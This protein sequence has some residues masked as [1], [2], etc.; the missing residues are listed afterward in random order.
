MRYWSQ[1]TS[2]EKMVLCN[3]VQIL[4]GIGHSRGDIAKITNVFPVV[5][6]HVLYKLRNDRGFEDLSFEAERRA[7]PVHPNCRIGSGRNVRPKHIHPDTWVGSEM[8]W[9]A[10]D[11]AF[12][13]AM[14][15]HPE[16]RPTDVSLKPFNRCRGM[17]L[18]RPA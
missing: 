18:E 14:E 17:F 16:E 6:D 15:A 4:K 8:W 10:N 12:R 7:R 5:V 1:L 13:E 11:Q 3:R 9:R 2:V